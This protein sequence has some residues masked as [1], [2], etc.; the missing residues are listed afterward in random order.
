MPFTFSHPALI[1]PFQKIGKRYVSF[2]GLVM[3]SMIPDFEFFFKMR[4]GPNIGHHFPGAFFLNIPLALILCFIFHEF[5][6]RPLFYNV[7]FFL[8]ARLVKY[9]SFNWYQYA[10]K[11]TFVIVSS[12]T[13]GISTHLFWDAFTHDDGFFVERIRFLSVQ[14]SFFNYTFPMYAILQVIFSIVGLIAV[15]SCIWKMPKIKRL[16]PQGENSRYWALIGALSV[17]FFVIRSLLL[18]NYT[19][20]WDNFM[21]LMGSLIYAIISVSILQYFKYLGRNGAR[22]KS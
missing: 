5:V 8:K 19:T 22:D 13:F 18:S 11:N 17:L 4:T 3:G 7:P 12:I 10:I 14:V 1:L 9:V 16:V 20:F 6:K 15:G 2:T 21:G